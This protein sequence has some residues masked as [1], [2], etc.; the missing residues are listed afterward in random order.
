MLV[1][2]VWGMA[3]SGEKVAPFFSRALGS[4]REK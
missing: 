2:I 4:D 1:L 3:H